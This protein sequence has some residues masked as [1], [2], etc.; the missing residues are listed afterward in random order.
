MVSKRNSNSLLA[1]PAKYRRIAAR[2]QVS[3]APESSDTTE[4]YVRSP[5]ASN[6]E[7][8]LPITRLATTITRAEPEI[9]DI[10]S[11]EEVDDGPLDL[12]IDWGLSFDQNAAEDDDTTLFEALISHQFN[13]STSAFGEWIFMIIHCMNRVL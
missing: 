9:I 5:A 12:D 6:A 4:S 1:K 8:I 11:D 3:T 10:S 2:P 7:N 13:D